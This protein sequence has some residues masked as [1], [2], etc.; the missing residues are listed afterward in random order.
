MRLINPNKSF[1]VKIFLKYTNNLRE[2]NSDP[3]ANVKWKQRKEDKLFSV[4]S[5]HWIA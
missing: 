2:K 1:H 3:E 5:I 4:E